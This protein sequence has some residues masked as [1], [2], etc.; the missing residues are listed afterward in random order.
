MFLGED[1]DIEISEL[2]PVS[3]GNTQLFRLS[4]VDQH[5]FHCIFLGQPGL[6]A[7]VAAPAPKMRV[8]G[9]SSAPWGFAP[10]VLESPAGVATYRCLTGRIDPIRFHAHGVKHCI[11]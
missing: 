4:R 11:L 5:S 3:D 9:A 10:G 2:L 6:C 7:T 1:L 8:N